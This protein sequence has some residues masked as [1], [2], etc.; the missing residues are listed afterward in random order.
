MKI[1]YIILLVMPTMVNGQKS[2]S[3]KEGLD[4]CQSIIEENKM[5]RPDTFIFIGPDCLIGAKVPEFS[6]TSIDGKEIS[7]VYFKGKITILNFWSLSCPPCL[8]ETPG[9]NMVI[10][11]FGHEKLNYLAISRDD[12][13]DVRRYLECNSWGF[14]QI[15]SGMDIT[16][17]LFKVTWGFPTTFVINEEAVIIAAFSGGRSDESAAKELEDKLSDI[18]TEGLK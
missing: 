4:N 3:Y 6:A 2:I 12:A 14:T 7:E 10:D 1:V 9:F 15:A 17:K 18:I 8:A 16:M 5:T 11:K 13:K